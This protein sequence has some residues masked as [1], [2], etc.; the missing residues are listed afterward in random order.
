MEGDIRTEAAETRWLFTPRAPW[1]AGEYRLVA[2]SILEDV[3]GNR[4]GHAFEV[5]SLTS[6]KGGNQ[7]TSV[8]VPFRLLSRPVAPAHGK[9]RR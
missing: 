9:E 6:S 2:S 5:D 4:I 8:E 3:A 7:A 1:R